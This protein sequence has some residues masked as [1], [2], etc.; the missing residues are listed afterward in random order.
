MKV[1]Q[2]SKKVEPVNIIWTILA[3]LFLGPA[4]ACVP[5]LFYASLSPTG[6][7][8]ASELPYAPLL[9][10]TMWWFALLLIKGGW[11]ITLLPTLIAALTYG[12]FSA[13][14]AEKVS[15]IFSSKRKWVLASTLL[16]TVIAAVVF[17]SCHSLYFYFYFNDEGEN[18]FP[19]FYMLVMATTTGALLGAGLAL[20]A[21]RSH[22]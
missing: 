6:Q 1:N 14:L 13:V 16:S 2:I 15:N 19:A 18:P 8:E 21:P 11:A 3:F 7:I 10:T 17:F 22:K 20:V 4:L 5:Y 9:L 12:F